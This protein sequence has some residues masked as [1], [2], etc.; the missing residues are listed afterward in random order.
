MR[1]KSI[2][3]LALLSGTVFAVVACAQLQSLSRQKPAPTPQPSAPSTVAAKPLKSIQKATEAAAPA[4]LTAISFPPD[5]MVVH[6]ID[7]G[8]GDA[9]LLEFSCG[10]VLVDTGGETTQ[11]VD[12]RQNLVDFLDAFFKR[13]TDLANTLKLV[14]LSHPHIDHTN[15]VGVA[16]PASGLLGMSV[17][18]E[19][20]VDDG[21]PLA[22][23][24]GAPGQNALKKRAP[25]GHYFGVAAAKITTTAGLTNSIIDPVNCSQGGGVDPK[26]TALWGLVDPSVGS[27]TTNPNNNSVVIRVDFG[28]ASFLFMGDMEKPGIDAMLESYSADTSIFDADVLKVGHHG[29]KNGTTEELLKAVTPKIAVMG[30]GDSSMSH[31]V[32]SAYSFAHPNKVAI[33]LLLDNSFGV[34]MSRPSKSV[35]VGIKGADQK[36]HVP[37]EFQK[38]T[39]ARAIYAT[40]WDGTVDVTAHAD[41]TL[42]VQ[43]NQ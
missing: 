4:A 34:T 11:E 1:T 33:D 17:T 22:H 28:A 15:G 30:V 26:I 42:S 21:P 43:T 8:Q 32:Y 31:A 9:E 5:Q 35:S 16:Y 40:G 23:A 20:V 18:I 3:R 37:P 14:V 38:M 12:G 6:F 25:S 41:G 27:W 2:T 39:I 19:N 36:H 7:V 13:R 29:S 24:T 10:A